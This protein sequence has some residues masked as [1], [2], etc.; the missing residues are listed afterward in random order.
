MQIVI[1]GTVPR[2]EAGWGQLS[3]C[4]RLETFVLKN[5]RYGDFCNHMSHDFS[6]LSSLKNL[7]ELE[8]HPETSIPERLPYIFDEHFSNLNQLVKLNLT[9]I[10][11]TEVPQALT[12]RLCACRFF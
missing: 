6:G 10:G 1:D 9:S 12:G 8:L 3:A 4:S 11:L 7:K 2:Q 5:G